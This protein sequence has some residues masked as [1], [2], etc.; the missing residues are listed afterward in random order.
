MGRAYG[1]AA[2]AADRLGQHLVAARLY[3]RAIFALSGVISTSA[4]NLLQLIAAEEATRKNPAV[5][6]HAL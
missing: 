6:L 3:A 1:E 5:P 4:P 2:E